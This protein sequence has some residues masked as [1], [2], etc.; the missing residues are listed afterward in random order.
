MRFSVSFGAPL[1]EIRRTIGSNTALE[2]MKTESIRGDV[3]KPG[4]IGMNGRLGFRT[5]DGKKLESCPSVI[6]GYSIRNASDMISLRI[7]IDSVFVL[8]LIRALSMRCWQ[9]SRIG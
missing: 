4:W 3:N 1:K 2:K 5:G 6:F 9:R 8:T 7:C